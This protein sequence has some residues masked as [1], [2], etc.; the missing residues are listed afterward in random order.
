MAR[1][2]GGVRQSPLLEAL[3]SEVFRIDPMRLVLLFIAL[4]ALLACPARA[5]RWDVV[6]TALVRETYT[7][8]VFLAPDSLKQS[9]WVTQ[10]IPGISVMA[11]GARLRFNLTYAPEATYYGRETK[12]SEFFHR[13][14]AF[15]VAELAEKLLFLEGGGRIDQYDISPLGPVTI[16]NINPTGNRATVGSYYASP[17]LRRTLGS[18]FL[19]EARYTYSAVDTDSNPFLSNSVSNRINLKLSGSPAYK[20]LTW[21]LAY[22]GENIRYETQEDTDTQV[23]AANA[24]R[25]I[26]HSVGLLAQVG[27][28]YYRTGTLI[29]ASEGVSWAAGFDWTPSPVT[30]LAA[31]AGQRFYGNEYFLDF[32]HRTRLTTWSVGYSQIVTTT[33]SQFFVPTTTSTAG[34]LDTLYSTRFPDPAARQKVVDDFIARTGLPSSLLSPVNFFTNQLFLA[35]RWH[36]SAAL[37]GVSHVVIANVFDENREGVAG[38]L[39]LPNAPNA[40]KQTG[41]SVTWNWRLTA[42]TAWN[43]AGAYTRIETPLTG[44]IDYFTFAGTGITRQFQPRVSGSLGYRWQQRDSNVGGINYTENAGFASLEMRF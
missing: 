27:H 32:R 11:T 37:Q 19:G 35:K 3:G 36:A 7:D 2:R 33:R 15:G 21:D 25:L 13:G 44:T 9:D 22:T 4:P 41:T 12:T 31:T 8:N 18:A 6:P 1:A 17:Y 5:A 30:R 28:D 38:D 14:N 10:V 24:R 20:L 43:L 16:N 39:V 26:T 42:Q 34:Y 40:N 23:I 29:P